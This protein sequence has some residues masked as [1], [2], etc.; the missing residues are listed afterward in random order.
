MIFHVRKFFPINLTAIIL[1]RTYRGC[2]FVGF[3]FVLRCLTL[4]I[5]FLYLLVSGF[6][7]CNKIDSYKFKVGTVLN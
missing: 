6:L 5:Y 7:R 2:V 1:I 3:C 4:I